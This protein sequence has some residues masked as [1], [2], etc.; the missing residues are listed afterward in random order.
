MTLQLA[1]ICKTG[2]PTFTCS[3]LEHLLVKIPHNRHLS[4][5]EDGLKKRMFLN[6]VDVDNTLHIT[7]N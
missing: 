2:P 5:K 4:K 6:C 3:S 7:Y 1:H